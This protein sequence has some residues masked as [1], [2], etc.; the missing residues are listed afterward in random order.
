MDELIHHCLRELAFDGELGS[1]VSRLKDFIVDFYAHTNSSHTQNPDDT[2]CA[3][4]WALVVQQPSTIVGVVSPELGSEVWIAPRTSAMRK[5]QARG[6]D[7]V[8]QQP[9]QLD[10][11]SEPKTTS[12]DTL[13]HAYGDR[14]RIAVEPDSIFAAITGSHIRS[15]KMSPMVYSALQIITR[16]RDSGVTVVDLGKQ[17]GYD[18]KTCFY[19]VRQ[20]TELEL[21]VKVRRGGVGT[22]F[23]IHKYFFD[24]S[25][26]W[27]A[28]RDEETQ[29]EN[30]QTTGL[31]SEADLKE[32]D[33]EIEDPAALNFTPIDARHLSSLP[34]ISGRVIRLLK[35]SKNHMHASNNMLITLGFSNPTKTDR[36]FF[37][38]RIREMIQQRLIE[39]VVVPSNKRKSNSKSVKCFRLVKQEL[40]SHGDP[41]PI[42]SDADDDLGENAEGQNGIKLNTT[43]HKQIIDQLEDSGTSG[44]TLNDLSTSLC[45]FDKRTIELLLSRAVHHHPPSHLSDLRIAPLI[46][47]SGRERRHRYITVA[48]YR[49]LVAQ[50]KLDNKSFAGYDNIDLS[51]VGG[52]LPVPGSLFYEKDAEMIQFCDS[53]KRNEQGR[54]SKAGNK[55]TKNPI[56]PDGRIKRGRP[57]KNAI[58]NDG[59]VPSRSLRLQ[60]PKRK[61]DDLLDSTQ[62]A[63][64]EDLDDPPKK[65]TRHSKKPQERIPDPPTTR[66]RGRPRKIKI[67]DVIDNE[68]YAEDINMDTSPKAQKKNVNIP[69]SKSISVVE[70]EP[71]T[72][73]RGELINRLLPDEGSHKDTNDHVFTVPSTNN[74]HIEQRGD[75]VRD[76]ARSM[77]DIPEIMNQTDMRSS[78]QFSEGSQSPEKTPNSVPNAA[79]INVSQLRR[80]NELLRVVENAG[81][82]VNIQN[83]EF[84][85]AHMKLLES[86]A[87]AGEPTSAPV[88]T[89]TD[90]RTATATFASLENKGRIKQ[91][92][93]S[94]TTFTGVTRPACIVYLPHIEQNQIN[95]FLAELARSSQQPA[96]H[97]T[98]FVKIDRRLDYGAD[99]SSTSRGILP[100]QLLQLERPSTND[101]E[102]WSKNVSRAKQLFTHDDTTI[103]DVFLAERTTVAQL[104]GFIVGKAL[105]C[106]KL[107]LAAIHAFETQVDSTNIVS[108]EKRV[109][110][111]SFFC[112]DLPLDLYC[113]LVSP[114][115]FDEEL[116]MK[117][118]SSMGQKTLVRDLP[119][120]LQTLLQLGRSRARSRI[121]DMLEILRSLNLVTPLRPSDSS[122]EEPFLSC[123]P[124]GGHPTSFS[125]ASLDGWTINTPMIAP[126]YWCF[127]ESSS[128]HLYAKSEIHPPYW[129]TN[130]LSSYFDVTVYWDQ[131][132]E[133]CLNTNI[134]IDID[135]HSSQASAASVAAARSLRRAASWKS[136]YFLTWHQM[137]YMKQYIDSMAFSTPLQIS[138][139]TERRNQIQHIAWVISAPQETVE[140]FFSSSRDKLIRT[141]EKMKEKARKTQKRTEEAKLSL[142]KKAEEARTQREQEWSKLLVKSHAT[143][144]TGPA[145]VRLERIRNQFLQSISL[146]NASEWEKDI[147]S[148][149]DEANWANSKALKIASKSFSNAK[150]PSATSAAIIPASESS[151]QSLIESQGPPLQHSKVTV[152]RKKRKGQNADP[153]DSSATIPKKVT[154]RHRFQWNTEYDELAR[155]ASAIIRARCRSLSRLDWG[156]F[157]QVFPSV[158]RNTVRQRLAHIK[159]TP[160]N[161][162]YLR[163]LEDTWYDIWIKHRGTSA[164][165]DDDFGSASNFNLVK[166]IEFLRAHVDKN[167]IRVGFAQTKEIATIT[168]PSDVASLMETYN[169]VQA[170]KTAPDWDFMWNALIEEGREKRL[171]K[172]VISRC[173]ENFPKVRLSELDEI[174]L[175]ESTL[176]M[177]M[178]TPPERY[179]PAQGSSL[180]KNWGQDVIDVATKNLLTRGVLSKSQRDPLKQGPGRQLK[181][182]EANQNAIGGNITSDTFQDATSLL[183][184]IDPSDTT[185]HDWPLTA[186]DGD[187][188]TLI[189][190]VSEDKVDFNIDTSLPRAERPGLDW[191]SKKADDDQIETALAVRYRLDARASQDISSDDPQITATSADSMNECL[192]PSVEAHTDSGHGLSVENIPAC[193]RRLTGQG[194]IDCAMCLGDA[195]SIFRISLS[196]DDQETADWVLDIVSQRRESGIKKGD[197]I[198]LAGPRD[199]RVAIVVNQMVEAE[200][201]LIHWMGY[202]SLVLVS[203]QYLRKWTVVVSEEPFVN[204]L[205]RRWLDIRGNRVADFWQS[206]LRAV[207]GLIVFRPGITQASW[208]NLELSNIVDDLPQT[209][210]RWRLRA[211]YDRQEVSEIL[212]HLRREGYLRVRLGYSSVWTTC[213]TE[214]PFDEVEE[215]KVF[216]FIGDKHWYQL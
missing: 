208:S 83:K 78:S 40:S 31:D 166:H 122:I 116:A 174:A 205:P 189:E 129:K 125:V 5:A 143:A 62:V 190:L 142:A 112:H 115:T 88:G 151:I 215:R 61:R 214:L 162:A 91:L 211:V 146:K 159:E 152:K 130:K 188:A 198:S 103:R 127:N 97:L 207:M 63:T 71:N 105:R 120:H 80:E 89:K 74:T 204:A 161:E 133:A 16:G 156:A 101:K 95:E 15:S 18:Q 176:K 35:A 85:Q 157:E 44:M 30:L 209:E 173:P 131:L 153:S 84:Y 26:S 12:L 104:Y 24:R 158:P 65:K 111:L 171:K 56:L 212:R 9:P 216:W 19:L 75:D 53:F 22:H 23:C 124:K 36:R 10:P 49:K 25:S 20:L 17:S 99:T 81:G 82:I 213:G 45:H 144:L 183:E 196:Q 201:P 170:E 184:E 160:G 32:E 193:C 137:Q 128:I 43:L 107:H 177:A 165:P 181:I 149:L 93:T 92:R 14:L 118:K 41:V 134:N 136:E 66:G 154:R 187:C 34:L 79:R 109:I 145:V 113:S 110:D 96:S 121:L 119:Q 150:K 135:V 28:I 29:A 7:H 87:Q 64:I 169:V 203:A 175:A 186:T 108:H 126:N 4:V 76:M 6:E 98:S 94:V 195:W 199:L 194:L 37:Q 27:K 191:N 182:S 138:D 68:G 132:R 48:N 58:K 33:E 90:K 3:F 179:D 59:Q 172:A 168:L 210:I 70:G 11:I 50:E 54:I 206:G 164:L 55:K 139:D 42:L 47:T 202:D 77:T 57:R 147:Q 163:R 1:N 39:K 2:F 60:A 38:S 114:L 72:S 140:N 52:F 167:A 13:Q 8:E 86:L 180:L 123:I 155:D 51:D 106:R 148:T 69:T 102:R 200:I 178:G 21:V 46:E 67:A 141:S 100:L 73:E 192:E 185:W 197:L 117:T